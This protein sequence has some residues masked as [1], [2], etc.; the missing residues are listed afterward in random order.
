MVWRHGPIHA[1]TVLLGELVATAGSRMKLVVV[2]GKKSDVGTRLCRKI[3]ADDRLLRRLFTAKCCFTLSQ[4]GGF[5]RS[6]DSRV[7]EV[8]G[9][10]APV[11]YKDCARALECH[12][13]RS[14]SFTPRSRR[15]FS[16]AASS[17]HAANVWAAWRTSS[18]GGNVGAM[19][20]LVS[21]GSRP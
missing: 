4:P 5:Y 8:S 9:M 20:R 11:E 17:V 1:A 7:T 16:V 10:P 2:E 19:R 18:I 12:S 3:N 15:T 13:G 14:Q 6:D 21:F